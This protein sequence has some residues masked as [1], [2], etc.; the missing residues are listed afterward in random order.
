MR[1]GPIAAEH[2]VR[3]HWHMHQRSVE[4]PTTDDS[5]HAIVDQPGLELRTD[6]LIEVVAARHADAEPGMQLQFHARRRAKESIQIDA[7]GQRRAGGGVEVKAFAT[8][9]NRR[10]QPGAHGE[11]CQQTSFHNDLR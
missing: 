11:D 2:D 1:I 7:I 4:V 3:H 10:S 9:S 5:F 8:T 6:V